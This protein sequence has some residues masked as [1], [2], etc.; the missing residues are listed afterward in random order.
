[1]WQD[2]N[3]R[4]NQIFTGSKEKWCVR[5]TDAGYWVALCHVCR[6]DDAIAFEPMSAKADA[7]NNYDH[8]SVLSDGETFDGSFG[9]YVV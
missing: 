6:G 3:Y 5:E 7:F 8:L 1:M 2:S 9:F 4:F